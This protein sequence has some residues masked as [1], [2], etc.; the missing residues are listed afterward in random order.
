MKKWGQRGKTLA[1]KKGLGFS[2][3]I[4]L[5]LVNSS[6]KVLEDLFGA[7]RVPCLPPAFRYSPVAVKKIRSAFPQGS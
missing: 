2:R 3:G 6:S 7:S 4:S 1:P 5:D